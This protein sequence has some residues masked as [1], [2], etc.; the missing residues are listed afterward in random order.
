MLLLQHHGQRTGVLELIRRRI[1]ARRSN[2]QRSASGAR[3]KTLNQAHI[4]SVEAVHELMSS[5]TIGAQIA[6]AFEALG[7][8]IAAL[9]LAGGATWRRSVGRCVARG[10]VAAA[11]ASL[12]RTHD[13]T[14]DAR[15]APIV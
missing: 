13:Q 6:L 5:Y 7:H 9:A 4:V 3:L 14:A 15:V 10:A 8:R 12:A 2:R 11:V 1:V